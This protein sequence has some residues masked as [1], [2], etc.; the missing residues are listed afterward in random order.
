MRPWRRPRG[1]ILF[2]SIQLIASAC[3]STSSPEDPEDETERTATIGI[4]GGVVELNN[5]ASVVVPAGSFA[6]PHIVTL[7]ET[8][9]DVSSAQALGPSVVLTVEPAA[10]GGVSPATIGPDISVCIPSSNLNLG[11][12]DVVLRSGGILSYVWATQLGSGC[13][14][15]SVP[16]G[17]YEAEF[18]AILSER[19]STSCN[20]TKLFRRTP[21][22]P[23]SKR[24]SI[25]LIHGLQIDRTS[26]REFMEW[27]DAEVAAEWNNFIAGVIDCPSCGPIDD[28]YNIYFFRYPTLVTPDVAAALLRAELNRL[29]AEGSAQEFEELV[30]VGHSMGGLVAR[31]FSA[32][33][34]FSDIQ[35]VVTLGTP[36]RGVYKLE[37][38]ASGVIGLVSSLQDGRVSLTGAL[39]P[40]S[41]GVRSLEWDSNF[42]ADLNGRDGGERRGIYTIAGDISASPQSEPP[43]WGSFFGTVRL[44][45]KAYEEFHGFDLLESA[46]SDGIVTTSSALLTGSLTTSPFQGYNHLELK[47]GG[48]GAPES[49]AVFARVRSI[50]LD[51][52]SLAREVRGRLVKNG[53]GRAGWSMYLVVQ[54]DSAYFLDRIIEL[55]QSTTTTDSQG[56][57]SFFGLETN[58]TYAIIG[59]NPSGSYVSDEFRSIHVDELALN[60]GEALLL[61]EVDFFY[62]GP[63]PNNN[64]IRTGIGTG[65]I[66]FSWNAYTRGI[67]PRYTVHVFNQLDEHHCWQPAFSFVTSV[68]WDLFCTNA[69]QAGRPT[70]EGQHAWYV[71]V[72]TYR[73]FEARFLG[74]SYGDSF[75]LD[76]PRFAKS[77]LN[78]GQGLHDGTEPPYASVRPD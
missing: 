70:V 1:Y 77:S 56:Y 21:G 36:H 40:D 4:E 73:G 51:V 17:S 16:P 3:G 72:E 34:E 64:T 62:R 6:G 39:W 69:S 46:F 71:I 68:S 50:L 52:G 58:L 60:S 35:K 44:L 65:S 49:D 32:V 26:C 53:V 8:Q 75:I 23:S 74:Y 30:L 63:V 66:V 5:G 15:F 19:S 59:R 33:N 57:F 22:G 24:R 14:E 31:Y 41:P 67:S 13:V 45:G 37:R 55:P 29:S 10:S 43:P 54:P 28:S 20:A 7:R 38:R 47:Q 76:D 27:S 12:V 61:P 11:S 9:T 25:V 42:L 48:G 2:A 78:S 18:Q